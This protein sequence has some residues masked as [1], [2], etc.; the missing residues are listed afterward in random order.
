MKNQLVQNYKL[1]LS[2]KQKNV[3]LKRYFNTFLSE[4]IYRT[5]KLEHK[6]VTRK[7]VNSYL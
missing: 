5:T 7:Q 3:I 6:D 4:A 1:F 2:L